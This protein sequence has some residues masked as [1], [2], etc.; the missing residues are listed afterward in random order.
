MG[1]IERLKLITKARI[2]AFLCSIENP[3]V[4]LPQLIRE[5]ADKINEAA[6]AESKALSAVK[7]D[8]R[9][10]DTAAGRIDRFEKGAILAVKANEINTARQA[11]AAQIEA[12]R[13]AEKCR[14]SLTVSE[15]A[16][17]AAGSVRRQLQ[18]NLNELKVKKDQI[19]ARAYAAEQKKSQAKYMKLTIDNGSSILDMVARLEIKVEQAEAEVEIRDQI[20]RTL[21]LTFPH[22]RVVKLEADA[23]VGRRLELLKR[24][25]KTDSQ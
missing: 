9:R 21:G 15:S 13:E 18:D 12:E 19:L 17:N 11:I 7:A 6:K 5:M 24:R 1:R 14:H 22:E 8:R 25:I 2:E 20:S 16:Y 10:V 4:I 23:E 3:E